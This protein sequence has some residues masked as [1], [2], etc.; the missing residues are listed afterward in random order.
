MIYVYVIPH[1]N[2]VNDWHA[3]V[4]VEQ[5]PGVL[6]AG[7]LQGV[8]E[9]VIFIEIVVVNSKGATICLRVE[10]KTILILRPG[11]V[12]EEIVR[13]LNI[14]GLVNDDQPAKA[15][16]VGPRR[17]DIV[18]NKCVSHSW[19]RV[20]IAGIDSEELHNGVYL[21]EIEVAV[22]DLMIYAFSAHRHRLEEV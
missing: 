12:D 5:L 20:V 8:D 13:E 17:R 16:E 15:H 6:R 14:E 10:H 21:R 11:H 3:V 9:G 18:P 7:A 22:L 1:R 19:C 4:I 2:L